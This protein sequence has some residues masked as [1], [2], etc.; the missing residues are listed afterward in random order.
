[1]QRRNQRRLPGRQQRHP[2]KVQQQLYTI[3]MPVVCSHMLKKKKKEEEEEEE[4]E[5]E[6]E[7][8]EEEEEKEEK[9]EKKKK[10]EE[11]EETE[12]N[13]VGYDEKRSKASQSK[14]RIEG[15]RTQTKE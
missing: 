8:E 15:P 9:E 2:C 12:K 6:E 4:E 13:D 5:A 3:V 7:E 11:E 10:E 14:V 1:M